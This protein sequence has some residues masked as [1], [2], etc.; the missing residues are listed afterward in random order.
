MKTC[1]DVAVKDFLQKP[2][3]LMELYRR[4]CV[5][6]VQLY[7]GGI[8]Y[9]APLD[10][11]AKAREMLMK[12]GFE[13]AAISV[14]VGHPKSSDLEPD[15]TPEQAAARTRAEWRY[16][17]G[18]DGKPEYYSNELTDKMIADTVSYV[19]DYASLGFDLFF[20][21]DDC[22]AANL[23]QQIGGCFCPDCKAEF[24]RRTGFKAWD[25]CSEARKAWTVFQSERVTRLMKDMRAHIAHPGLMI[26]INGDERHGVA[27]RDISFIDGAHVRVGEAHFFDSDARTLK[28]RSEEY[29][30]IA[31]HLYRLGGRVE[32]YSE[33]TAV[34][35]NQFLPIPLTTP[36]HMYSKAI[37]ALTAGVD[38]IDWMCHKHWDMMGERNDD[39]RAFAAAA[40]GKRSW[41]VHIARHSQIAGKGLYT[42][43]TAL[44]AGLPATGVFADEAEASSLLVIDKELL[45]L[46]EWKSA[47]GKYQ[48]VVTT[49]EDIRAAARSLDIPMIDKGTAFISWI[50]EKNRAVVYNPLEEQQTVEVLGRQLTLAAGEGGVADQK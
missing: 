37:L 49:D 29:L 5:D 3:E 6:Q 4:S 36:Q 14:P 17:I 22:R 8:T 9:L 41:P 20:L 32:T 40:E 21:D 7:V 31:S 30:A 10:E 27:T 25:E 47:A 38:N 18:P 42:N 24:T 23:Q 1:I 46:P 34:D 35:P 48:K 50:P 13:T 44:M 39:L 33:S 28:G 16:R 11:T 26:M 15:P 19:K 45:T 2:E 43:D 12:A